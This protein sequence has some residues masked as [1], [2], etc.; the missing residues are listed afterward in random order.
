MWPPT[1]RHVM[2]FKEKED[3]VQAIITSAAVIVGGLWTYNVFIIER[4]E[5]PRMNIEQKLSHVVLSDRVNILRAG[6]ELRNTG[7]YSTV[8]VEREVIRIQQIVPSICPKHGVCSTN[9]VNDAIN[10]VERQGDHFTWPLVAERENSFVPPLEI[11]PKENQ[12]LEFEFALP[13]DIKVVRIYSY[14]TTIRHR[15]VGRKIWLGGISI[16]PRPI[17]TSLEGAGASGS[18]PGERVD[19]VRETKICVATF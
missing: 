16:L 17:A 18:S 19:R 4:R 7:T 12:S 1:P 9:E 10:T 14:L 11:A 2:T 15:P 3:T 5:D 13:S 6:I 8:R